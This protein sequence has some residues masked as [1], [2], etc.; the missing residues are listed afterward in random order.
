MM[1]LGNEIDE[2]YS[3]ANSKSRVAGLQAAMFSIAPMA[4]AIKSA[5]LCEILSQGG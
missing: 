3:S 4:G 1:R 5:K 2:G